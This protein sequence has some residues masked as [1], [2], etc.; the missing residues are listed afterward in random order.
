MLRPQPAG[1]P[2]QPKGRLAERSE[3]PRTADRATS[4]EG[5]PGSRESRFDARYR[6]RRKGP[7][8]ER[9]GWPRQLASG[10]TDNPPIACATVLLSR[11]RVAASEVVRILRVACRSRTWEFA[12]QSRRIK[13]TKLDVLPVALRSTTRAAQ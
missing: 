10:P 5:F 11:W 1:I 8:A 7:V 6:V 12:L 13:E 9:L 4:G 2:R 3:H